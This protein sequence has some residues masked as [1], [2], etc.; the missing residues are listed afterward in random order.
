[1]YSEAILGYQICVTFKTKLFLA[2]KT[3]TG[4]VVPDKIVE[5]LGKGK[6]P[7]VKVTING[8]TYRSTIALMSGEYMLPV[9]AE[10]R[11]AARISAGETITVDVT[12]DTEPRV[13]EIPADLAKALAK[14]ENAKKAFD[15]LSY[16]NQKEIVFALESAKTDETR[17]RRLD[18]AMEKLTSV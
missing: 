5:S 3:A 12:L 9:R 1:L 15:K 17:S 18:K 6:R 4:I 10:V 11:D 16:T 8:F 14:S 13:V 2:G 7:P